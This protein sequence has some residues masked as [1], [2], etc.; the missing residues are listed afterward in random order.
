MC[1]YVHVAL[2]MQ[3]QLIPSVRG[4]IDAARQFLEA[5]DFHSAIEHLGEAIEV[6][7]LTVIMLHGIEVFPCVCPTPPL[8][9]PRLWFD[10]ELFLVWLQTACLE[11]MRS[12]GSNDILMYQSPKFMNFKFCYSKLCSMQSEVLDILSLNCRGTFER[13]FETLIL[14]KLTPLAVKYGLIDCCLYLKS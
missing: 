11:Q 8:L 6:C 13:Y 4:H 9:I 5:R 2:S 1:M 3:L 14:W 12:E 10:Y 7:L